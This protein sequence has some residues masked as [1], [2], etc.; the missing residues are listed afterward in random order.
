MQLIIGV[1]RT[2]ET[3]GRKPSLATSGDGPETECCEAED[4]GVGSVILGLVFKMRFEM[5]GLT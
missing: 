3:V 4:S 1:A 2:F 5:A